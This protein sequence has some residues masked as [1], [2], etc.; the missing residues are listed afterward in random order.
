M[1]ALAL[2]DKGPQVHVPR[3][4]LLAGKGR[5]RGEIQHRLGNPISGVVPNGLGTGVDL[6]GAGVRPD[7]QPIA[8]G[9]VDG[10]DHQLAQVR[11]HIGTLIG[12][13]TQIGRDIFNLGRLV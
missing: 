13:L 2:Q 8:A 5:H 1:G 3:G 6:L 10:L 11:Q 12:T 4:H 9:L 7:H